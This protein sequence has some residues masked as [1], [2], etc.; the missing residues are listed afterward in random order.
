MDIVI[1]NSKIEGKGIFA[2][3]DFEKGEVIIKWDISSKV[4]PNSIDM[5][6]EADKRRVVNV[7]D[8]YI[9]MQSPEIY[10]NHSCD[11]N[12]YVNNFYDIARRN[13]R[14][15][16]EITTDYSKTMTPEEFITYSGIK[17]RCGSRSCIGSI[18]AYP[19]LA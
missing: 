3:R 11:P 15:G 13:I 4:A 14:K 17:C 10:V 1:E 12:T 16:E 8:E 6:L 18:S 9:I 2:L 7:N 19:K 5:L